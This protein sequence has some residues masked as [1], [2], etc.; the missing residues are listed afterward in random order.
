MLVASRELNK[1]ESLVHLPSDR[2]EKTER[3]HKVIKDGG[4]KATTGTVEHLKERG[5]GISG[6][7]VT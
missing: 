7:V 2:L 5:R 6:A 1:G 4:G 3:D